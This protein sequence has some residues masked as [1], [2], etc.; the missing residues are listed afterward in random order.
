MEKL[1]E[2]MFEDIC[3]DEGFNLFHDDWVEIIDSLLTSLT[4][5]YL[6]NDD[7]RAVILKGGNQAY[8]AYDFDLDKKTFSVD[9]DDA[10]HLIFLLTGIDHPCDNQ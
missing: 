2:D 10:A 6:N 3:L 7:G 1:F 5:S 9:S 8:Y 4:V